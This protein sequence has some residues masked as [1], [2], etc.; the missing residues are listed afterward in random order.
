MFDLGVVLILGLVIFSGIILGI[1][2]R[3]RKS[4]ARQELELVSLS[5]LTVGWC[6][7]FQY[8]V[9]RWFMS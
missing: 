4:E 7:T 5:C 2:A 3:F 1:L 9:F 6:L 8:L